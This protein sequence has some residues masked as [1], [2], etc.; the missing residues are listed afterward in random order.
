MPN[1][2]GRTKGQPQTTQLSCFVPGAPTC[3]SPFI[4]KQI[5]P[6]SI[7]ATTLFIIQVRTV[8]INQGCGSVPI[9][10]LWYSLCTNP[11]PDL[12]FGSGSRSS[13]W[14]RLRIRGLKHSTWQ[15]ICKIF[16]VFCIIFNFVLKCFK[17]SLLFL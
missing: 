7:P 8:G 3:L 1:A 13:I 16:L 4:F 9:L 12:A 6:L 15:K 14:I 11:G 17:T 10:S 5:W 2:I